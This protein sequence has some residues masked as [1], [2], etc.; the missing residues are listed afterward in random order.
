MCSTVVYCNSMVRAAGVKCDFTVSTH[1]LPYFG[2]FA[3]S[4]LQPQ[5]QPVAFKTIA[6]KYVCLSMMSLY[7]SLY[8][9]DIF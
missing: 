4:A 9:I 5:I 7:I 6:V 1:K 3:I 2:R 8:V